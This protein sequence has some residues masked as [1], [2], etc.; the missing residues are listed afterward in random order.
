MP[1][2]LVPGSDMAGEIISLGDEAKGWKIGDRVSPNFW[3]DH[4]HGPS[5]RKIQTTALGSGVHGVLT[6]YKVVPA[7]VSIFF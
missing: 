1:P 5:S 6:Q 3:L 4:I 2:N 7:H